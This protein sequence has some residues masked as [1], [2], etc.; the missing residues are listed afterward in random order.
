MVVPHNAVANNLPEGII[1]LDC[2]TE[3]VH[4]TYVIENLKNYSI[5][6]FKYY[7]IMIILSCFV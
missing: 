6:L 3:Y 2:Q 1:E 4:K 7:I 5:L